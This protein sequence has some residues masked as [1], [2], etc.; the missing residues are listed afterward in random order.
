[1]FFPTERIVGSPPVAESLFIPLH[2]EKL[3]QSN[4]YPQTI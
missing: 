2:E 1:M 3:P 4:L